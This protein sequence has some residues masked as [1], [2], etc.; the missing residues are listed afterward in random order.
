MI[1][2]RTLIDDVSEYL[3]DNEVGYEFTHWTERELASFLN[4]AVS[5][6]SSV[7]PS[8]FTTRITVPLVAG[9]V[10][11]V[12]DTCEDFVSVLGQAEADGSITQ[13]RNTSSK[14]GIGLNFPI[15]S[16]NTDGTYKLSAWRYDSDDANTIFVDPPVPAGITGSMVINCYN[17]PTIDSADAILRIPSQW[18]PAIFELML[19]YAYG[20]DIESVPNRDRSSTHWNNAV[21]IMSALGANITTAKRKTAVATGA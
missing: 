4:R 13:V 17:V 14:M 2:S 19:Y 6:V 5:L 9:T 20:V 18:Q 1:R 10:Q 15:C 3:R 21:T 8:L 7:R 12:P 16:A 11:A